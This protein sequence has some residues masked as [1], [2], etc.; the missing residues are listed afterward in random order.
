[1][2][3]HNEKKT[4][5]NYSNPIKENIL[6]SEDQKKIEVRL[7][8]Q[9]AQK[10][11][12]KINYLL[13]AIQDFS[14]RYDMDTRNILTG[15]KFLLNFGDIISLI[16]DVINYQNKIIELDI[17]EKE[18]I[19]EISQDYINN[20]SYTIFSFEKIDILSEEIK[21]KKKYRHKQ[22]LKNQALYNKNFNNSQI[23]F[24]VNNSN[25]NTYGNNYEEIDNKS[26]RI[27]T[28]YLSTNYLKEAESYKIK[29]QGNETEVLKEKEKDKIKKEI[30]NNNKNIINIK[31]QNN[32]ISDI[33]QNIKTSYK[34]KNRILANK[35]EE[36]IIIKK[37]DSKNKIK[38]NKKGKSLNTKIYV[39]N[40]RTN[41]NNPKTTKSN[42]N[43]DF[44]F[45]NSHI[46]LALKNN[47][48][49]LKSGSLK[50]KNTKNK[51]NILDAYN[52]YST[53]NDFEQ[54]LLDTQ[55]VKEGYVIK[56]K[57]N[58]Y[59]NVPKPSI[60]AN[61]LLESSKKFINDYNGVKKEE[62]KR[63]SFIN[64]SLNNKKKK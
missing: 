52:F 60:L 46:D 17:L 34:P 64:H 8:Y 55:P 23:K 32:K 24:S 1:M 63:N 26:S 36:K 13:K 35:S 30:K 47:S 12:Q 9:G 56:G 5:T 49:I 21:E 33:S 3:K 4:E 58:V 39:T 38:R 42:K 51:L 19:Q 18:K 62:K 59:S 27:L 44:N 14:N 61:K 16:K 15:K 37:E 2:N 41:Y 6:T 7:T 22:G 40:I 28:R 31:N 48:V 57:I 20:L 10:P 53:F 29:N 25:T 11:S 50:N 45:F 43:T 54:K